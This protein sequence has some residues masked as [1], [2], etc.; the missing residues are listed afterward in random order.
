MTVWDDLVGQ[1]AVVENLRRVAKG[2]G[3]THAWLFTGPPGSGRSNMALALAAALQC[4]TN[5]GCGECHSC[6]TVRT[7]SHADVSVIRTEKLSIGVD[8]VRDLVRRSAL[9]PAGDRWQIM[10]VEDSDRLTDHA[11]NALLKAIEE[12]T[13]RTVWTSAPSGRPETEIGTSPIPKA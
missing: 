3:M 11:C 5:S 4:E 8:E 2:E 7:G 10:V 13:A 1:Q 9:A 12:P 6:H